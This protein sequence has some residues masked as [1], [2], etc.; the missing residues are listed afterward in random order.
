MTQR[1]EQSAPQRLELRISP[2][3]R[4]GT[5]SSSSR[6]PGVCA[7]ASGGPDRHRHRGP[8]AV[9][10]L[11]VD[12]RRPMRAGG[13][14]TPAYSLGRRGV[15][16]SVGGPAATSWRDSAMPRQ[17]SEV[18]AA[19]EIAGA[20]VGDV[21]RRPVLHA[22]GGEPL[23]GTRGR[24]RRRRLGRLAG[25]ARARLRLPAG[26]TTRHC[27][28]LGT[29][30]LATLLRPT[31]RRPGGPGGSAGRRAAGSATAGHQRSVC[32][33]GRAGRAGCAGR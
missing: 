3:P 2:S 8:V 4:D 1:D 14:V 12:G 28:R 11:R 25:G 27:R 33:G 29:T 30:A 5:A 18:R 9:D 22:G 24:E 32:R 7:A 6:W 16:V 10:G 20:G 23:S 26:S 17:L 15:T 19:G 13:T 31:G 21:R